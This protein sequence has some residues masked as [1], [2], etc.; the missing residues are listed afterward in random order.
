MARVI[1]MDPTPTLPNPAPDSLP[2]FRWF[3]YENV[4]VLLTT[5]VGVLVARTLGIDAFG[6]LASGFALVALLS[7][8][9]D[10]GIERQVQADLTAKRCEAAVV[11]GTAMALRVAMAGLVYGALFLLAPGGGTGLRAVWL[12]AGLTWFLQSPHSLAAWLTHQGQLPYVRAT[13]YTGFGA[14]VLLRLGLV[15]SGAPA[16]WFA[17][18]LA[19]EATLSALIL[20]YAHGRLAPADEAFGWDPSL[21][22]RWLST[23]WRDLGPAF[24][25]LALLPLHQVLLALL[26]T[27]AEAGRFSAAVLL[28][29]A[30]AFALGAYWIFH[31][32]EPAGAP[33]AAEGPS[34]LA[35]AQ[36]RLVGWAW[37]AAAVI[38]GLSRWIGPVC[39]GPEFAGSALTFAA[40]GLCLL[41]F[42]LGLIR[43]REWTD[44]VHS[45]RTR[46]TEAAGLAMTAVL[47]SLLMVQ[48][49]ALGAA[50]G[51]GLALCTSQAVAT[52]AWADARPAGRAQLDALL[53]APLWRRR[54]PAAAPSE[55]APVPPTT[56]VPEA[57]AAEAA[58][59]AAQTN[60]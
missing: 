13:T 59:A 19:L 5:V 3:T 6:A 38:A 27:P 45:R 26:C 42:A 47:S 51:T 37:L 14:L 55:P 1:P 20:F 57:A 11:L 16:V 58:V 54:R 43:A 7:T 15:F 30:V 41:P 53:L 36:A 2:R 35:R 28:F 44:A 34:P 32:R 46:L 40:A 9:V 31:S 22:R 18:S 60:P 12:V 29:D 4:R 8:V 49:G 33:A 56:A 52:F 24:L 17:A 10:L 21:A 39:F 25:A 23:A 50:I 48:W